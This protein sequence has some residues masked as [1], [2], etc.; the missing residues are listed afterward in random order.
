MHL[1]GALISF[2]LLVD[3]S[4]Y[5]AAHVCDGALFNR[6]RVVPFR[7]M[8]ARAIRVFACMIVRY[9]STRVRFQDDCAVRFAG[10]NLVFQKKPVI[11]TY[12]MCLDL[13][14]I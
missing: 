8:L 4:S 7:T 6:W 11:I 10:L 2:S 14:R 5:L 1:V 13:T 3:N 9:L 12:S